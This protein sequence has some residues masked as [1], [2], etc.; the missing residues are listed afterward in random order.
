[1]NFGL[2]FFYKISVNLQRIKSV[3]FGIKSFFAKWGKLDKPH[4]GV[5]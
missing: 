1:M 4:L 2:V 5:C 3:K